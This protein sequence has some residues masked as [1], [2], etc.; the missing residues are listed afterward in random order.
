MILKKHKNALLAVIKESP[1][2]PTLFTAED[3]TIGD[4]EFFIIQLRNS[5]I[6]FAARPSYRGF[7]S[8]FYHSSI[9]S[10]TFPLSQLASA[11][12]PQRLFDE[13]EEWLNNVVKP[14]LDE[15]ITPDLW[16][17][18]EDTHS[19]ARRE[20]GAPDDFKP[21]SEEEK[22]QLKRSIDE[23]QL[24]IENNFNLNKKELGAIKKRLQYLSDAI[25]KH[26]R[27]DWK[28]IAIS[29]AIAIS[30]TLALNPEQTRQLFQLFKEAFSNLI[31]LL[32]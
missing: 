8:F 14:Y 6:R 12:N 3:A 32:P 24:S 21:F 16:Q 20:V 17:I 4:E 1:L 28:G 2:D 23:L 13:F 18:L 27:F 31:Y 26:N 22:F 15:V 10:P 5:P 29:T 9:F 30:V 19:E 7:D 11:G 25:D